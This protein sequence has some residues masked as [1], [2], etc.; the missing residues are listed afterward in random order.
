MQ[1]ELDLQRQFE[2]TLAALPWVDTQGGDE[3]MTND[4]IKELAW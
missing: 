2:A 3:D 1:P 4:M